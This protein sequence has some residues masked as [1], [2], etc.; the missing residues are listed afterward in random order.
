M[1]FKLNKLLLLIEFIL[2]FFGVPLFIFFDTDIIHPSVIILPILIAIFIYLNRVPDFRFKDL[3]KFNVDN[4]YF[5]KHVLFVV[6]ISLVLLLGVYLFDRENLFNL[7]K[8]NILIWTILCVFYPLFSAFGQ[9]IIY[10]VFLYY[11]YRN[12]LKNERL[13]VLASAIAFSFVHIVYYS[14]IS[15]I[16]TLLLG[17]YLAA[18]YIKTK[19]VLFTSMIHGFLGD[20]IFTV[21]L[22]SYFWLDINQWI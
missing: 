9:E 15:V 19:S 12:I 18:I 21:G 4:K 13:Y 5:K 11:R 20:V 17:L 10:R 8:G 3:V 7:P 6:I 1:N 16:L 2:L 14:H 22:G